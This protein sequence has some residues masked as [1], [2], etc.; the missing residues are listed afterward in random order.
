MD[1]DL[2]PKGFHFLTISERF[3]SLRDPKD[4][5]Y[6]PAAVDDLGLF[7]RIPLMTNIVVATIEKHVTIHTLHVH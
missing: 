7:E 5:G 1:M 4:L 6:G 3:L 2:F